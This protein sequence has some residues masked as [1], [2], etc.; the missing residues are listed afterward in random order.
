M[1]PLRSLLG[2]AT[3]RHWFRRSAIAAPQMTIRRQWPA[4]WRA[5]VALLAIVA[6]AGFALGGYGL[7]RS[8]NAVPA[9]VNSMQ[10]AASLA[11]T[12]TAAPRIQSERDPYAATAG[13]V[14]SEL[15]IER[16]TQ[17]QLV[18][19]IKS[20][21]TENSKLKED[22]AFFESLLPAERTS[23][24]V[25]IR[26][27]K[28]DI[29]G[30]NQLRYRLLVMQ[31]GKGDRDFVGSVQLAVTVLQNSKSVVLLFPGND[32]AAGSDGEPFQLAFKRYQRVEGLLTLPAGAQMQSVQAR[33][34]E[35]GQLR[36]QQTATIERS[37]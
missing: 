4:S 16:S 11:P 18:A 37:S 12:L 13:S 2:R 36:T 34:L 29:A 1:R 32:A 25:S 14:A 22:L 24:G 15:S 21:E 9:P 33:V 31:G 3:L 27:L 20:L 7:G 19:Q 10:S 28:A 5:T 17:Q 8:I 6:A 26:R 35:K 23:G 30:A